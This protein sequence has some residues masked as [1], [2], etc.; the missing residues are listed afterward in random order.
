MEV[1]TAEAVV[2]QAEVVTEAAVVAVAAEVLLPVVE[3]VPDADKK[4]GCPKGTLFLFMISD[5]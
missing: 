5:F 3:A 4:T 1:P 2:V